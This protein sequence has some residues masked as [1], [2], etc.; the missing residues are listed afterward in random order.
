[1]TKYSASGEWIQLL[2]NG[3][4]GCS[5]VQERAPFT[6][7]IFNS[8]SQ[9]PVPFHFLYRLTLMYGTWRVWLRSTP[10]PWPC[11]D[12][13]CSRQDTWG[14]GP[15]LVW[16]NNEV[17]QDQDPQHRANTNQWVYFQTLGFQQNIRSKR[18]GM[19]PHTV[20]TVVHRVGR[21]L[22]FVANRT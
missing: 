7:S 4:G 17:C 14:H 5:G 15:A 8:G 21:L 3:S 16:P 10:W 11:P 22:E 18:T 13:C 19:R 12:S 20:N 6:A 1:M 9:C 2:L